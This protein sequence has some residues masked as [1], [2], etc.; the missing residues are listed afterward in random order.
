V[1][2]GR[3]SALILILSIVSFITYFGVLPAWEGP[4]YSEIGKLRLLETLG[5]RGLPEIHRVLSNTH[6][7]LVKS[8]AVGAIGRLL[9]DESIE[10]LIK[11]LGYGGRWWVAWWDYE[12]RNKADGYRSMVAPILVKYGPRAV[13]HL[14]ETLRTGSNP[15]RYWAVWILGKIASPEAIEGL[16]S[17]AQGDPNGKIKNKAQEMLR[18]LGIGRS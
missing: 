13:P 15:Q 1:V 10:P 18:E 2:I 17:S 7:I 4:V 14:L 8:Y 12:E 11:E 5:E 6:S 16:K 3:R 9:K